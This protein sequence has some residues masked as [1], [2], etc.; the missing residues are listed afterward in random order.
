M[1]FYGYNK[2]STCRDASKW[3]SFQG[4]TV[5]SKEIRENPPSREE[6]QFA[7]EQ[8]GDVRKIL[9]TSGVEYRAM[10]L[11]DRL[12]SITTDEIFTLIQENGNL[13][14]RPFLIDQVNGVAL[15]GFKADEW[16]KVLSC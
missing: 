6:L 14:K 10:G 8:T 15:A 16:A 9:N 12:A 1:I 13:C 3:L 7:L 11:K 5:V 2:C 4:I